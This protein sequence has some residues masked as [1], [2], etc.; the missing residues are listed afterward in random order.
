MSRQ[1]NLKICLITNPTA[2][3]GIIAGTFELGTQFWLERNV[4]GRLL[5]VSLGASEIEILNDSDLNMIYVD[6]CRSIGFLED[7]CY[8]YGHP[9]KLYDVFRE[10]LH[11]QSDGSVWEQWKKDTCTRLT[12]SLDNR[13]YHPSN[14]QINLAAAISD[15]SLTS[16][17]LNRI[18]A[19]S[20]TNNVEKN[21]ANKA[22]KGGTLV[23]YSGI[24]I[25][26]R[27]TLV[28][29][30]PILDDLVN[31]ISGLGM[32]L[33]Q[34]RLLDDFQFGYEPKFSA[35][36]M[37]GVTQSYMRLNHAS[38]VGLRETAEKVGVLLMPELSVTTNVS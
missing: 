23:K 36:K 2:I 4:V 34:I 7:L 21:F 38:L 14:K 8:L 37:I 29:D 25:N 32:N 26:L 10:N 22:F 5:A 11:G 20:S 18:D 1:S 6:V 15:E 30:V 17:G 28:K 9:P 31:E 16:K 3:K 27:N 35:S 19:L 12:E 13:I 33:A 24:L